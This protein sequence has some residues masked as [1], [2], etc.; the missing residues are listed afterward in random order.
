MKTSVPQVFEE[1][2]KVKTKEDKIKVLR[3][4]DSIP[5]KGLL[6]INFHPLAK[7]NLPA[8]EPPFKKDTAIPDG[9]SESNLY[10][11]FRRIYIWTRNDVNLTRA[12]KEQLFIQLLEGIHWKEA[13]AI[14]LVKDRKLQSKYPSITYQLVYEAFPGLLPEYVEP[15]VNEEKKKPS[16]KPSVPSKD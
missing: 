8:G 9:Y 16:K 6:E 10:V 1:V 3:M 15:P 13:E 12:R 7:M 5:L 2:E 14:C 4:Y 11:E